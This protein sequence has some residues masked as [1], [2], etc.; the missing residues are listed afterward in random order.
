MLRNSLKF[1]A[2][3][4]FNEDQIDFCQGLFR[5]RFSVLR[6]PFDV[7]RGALLFRVCWR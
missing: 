5:L 1:V 4:D 7:V 3:H 2:V 6:N